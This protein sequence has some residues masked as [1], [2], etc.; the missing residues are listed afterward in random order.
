MGGVNITTYWRE[1]CY[2][3]LGYGFV[4]YKEEKELLPEI[5]SWLCLPLDLGGPL[6]PDTYGELLKREVEEFLRTE[7]VSPRQQPTIEEWVKTGKWME[8]KSGT[9]G[10][11]SVEIEG[12]RTRSARAKP[13]DGVL[14][15]DAAIRAELVTPGPERMVVMQ[16][17]EG[18]KIRGV[19]KTGNEVNRKMNYL[20][21]FL[22]VGLH[23]SRLSTLFAGERSGSVLGP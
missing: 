9:G 3:E 14:K 17:S 2:W 23:G 4:P 16:K 5:Q 1:L 10:T 8:G 21:A 20:S 7:W 15:T 11:T 22:E 18:G 19:V 12:R 13:V 6:G